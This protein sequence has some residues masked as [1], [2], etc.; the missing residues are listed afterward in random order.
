MNNALITRIVQYSK[1]QCSTIYCR[2][3]HCVLR[4]LVSEEQYSTTHNTR[5]FIRLKHCR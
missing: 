2:A 5:F 1:I 3:V 4:Q